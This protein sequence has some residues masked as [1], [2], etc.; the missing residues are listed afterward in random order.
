MIR[1]KLGALIEKH[2][3]SQGR[4]IT[5][6]EIADATSIN[7][8]TLSKILNQRGYNTGTDN[9]DR[10]CAYFG[11]RV[12]DVMEFVPLND[13]MVDSVSA[14]TIARRSKPASAVKSGRRG[15]TQPRHKTRHM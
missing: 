7:R 6:S 3:F 10:L 1:F 14:S 2:Q 9:I 13:P 4:R 8:I 12:E 11:C 5:I 15:P